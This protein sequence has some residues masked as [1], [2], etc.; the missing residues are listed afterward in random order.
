MEHM[1]PEEAIARIRERE[2]EVNDHF[3]DSSSPMRYP[4]LPHFIVK[5]NYYNRHEGAA[6]FRDCI[7]AEGLDCI[8]VPNKYPF[9]LYEKRRVCNPERKLCLCEYIEGTH[10][11]KL[12]KEQMRQ[13][14]ILLTKSKR[15][16]VDIKPSNILFT[17]GKKIAFI[18]LEIGLTDGTDMK[19]GLCFLKERADCWESIQQLWENI[20]RDDEAHELLVSKM[21]ELAASSK[22]KRDEVDDMKKDIKRWKK[23]RPQVPHVQE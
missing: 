19:T 12:N 9:T 7:I 16:Y 3:R 11:G 20:P 1:T 17:R 15:A 10:R 6:I 18:D 14:I 2:S 22:R 4:W 13:V 23:F 21:A 8:L 5:D